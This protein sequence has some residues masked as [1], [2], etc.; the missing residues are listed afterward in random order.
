MTLV[1]KLKSLLEDCGCGAEGPALNQGS[2]QA[3]SEY[4]M[5]HADG[6]TEEEASRHFRSPVP[7]RQAP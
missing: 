1:E 7:R 3:Q 4:P 2:D 5:D 6:E